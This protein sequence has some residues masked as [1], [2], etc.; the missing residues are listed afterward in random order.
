MGMMAGPM[1]RRKFISGG[2]KE[3]SRKRIKIKQLLLTWL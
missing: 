3:K 1:N 2:G